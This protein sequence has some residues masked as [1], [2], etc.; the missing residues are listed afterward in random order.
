MM[1]IIVLGGAGIWPT[2]EQA[3]SGYLV[4]DH[5]YRLLLDPGYATLPKLLE[6]YG[7]AD[8]DAVF[9]THEHPDHCADLS[10]LLRARVFGATSADTLPLYALAGSL[11]AVLALD[12]PTMLKDAYDLNT[13]GGEDVFEV[14]PFR[15]QTAMLPHFVPNAGVRLT[16][17]AGT[18][19]YT[20]DT[21]PSRVIVDLALGADVFIA[22]ATYV[23]DVPLESSNALLGAR[24][25]G[26]YAEESDV[27]HL[28]LTHLRPGTVREA[29]I[30]AAA[31]RFP[32]DIE[33]AVPGLV[34][35]IAPR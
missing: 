3:C 20:G 31:S 19:V 17:D 24:Q 13:I 10:P 33:V 29:S 30:H 21:G 28:L 25:A 11:D 22:E 5:D 27:R 34:V 9:V 12:E 18:I 8:I 35:D 6:R 23:D 32:R 14:G 15:V 2:A 7:V 4:E 16:T 1:Q 26:A